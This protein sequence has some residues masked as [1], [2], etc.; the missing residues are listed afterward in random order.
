MSDEY[1]WWRDGVIY[2]IY[3]RSYSDSN[4]DGFGDLPGI[5]SRLDYL[6]SLGVD[7]IWL[8]PVYPSPDADFGYDISNHVDIDPRFGD[9]SDFEELLARAH[10][11]NIRVIL[12]LV[13][14]HTSD[15]HAW[16]RESAASRTNPK[17]DWYIWREQRNDWQSAFGGKA[18]TYVPE[19]DQYYYHMFLEE[20]PDVNWRNPEVRQAQLEVVRFW[21]ERGVDGFRLDVFNAYFKD[22][23]FRNNPPAWGIRAFDRQRHIYD[24]D[25]P[26]MLPLLKEMRGILD[27]YDERYAVGETF[28]SDP[29]YAALYSG[30][31]MLQ[32][33]FNFD[34]THRPFS[35]RQFLDAILNWEQAS[36]EQV[37][38]N[39][40]LSNHDVKRSATRYARGEDDARA[41]V[42]L[43]LLLTMRGTPFLYYGEE[44]GMRDISLRRDQ[45]LDPPGKKYWPLYK[46]RDGC[47]SPMQW[48]RSENAGFSS[49]EPWLPVHPNYP[50][51]NAAAQEMDPHSLLNLT[52][53]LIKLRREQAALRRGTFNYR[54]G[55]GS[56]ALVYERRDEAQ[57][58]LVALNFSGTPVRVSV[59]T[60]EQVEWQL[61][62]STHR[63]TAPQVRPDLDLAPYEVCLLLE[64]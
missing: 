21:L 26:E 44:I 17:A 40:V 63:E 24:C 23:Q 14:N 5:I 35:A 57:A 59:N 34:F 4:G 37:W 27:Q 31:D 36:G 47:R 49:G 13:L 46:G 53:R 54:A 32:A 56:K 50:L 48:D 1:L 11:R 28:G 33:A 41:R 61:L 58:V 3:P 62:L 19:R 15:Q 60:D 20:Q 52:R 6:E 22:D 16:F 2:Q 25:R 8:S 45:I 39:Y 18:W 38:P 12:D 55:K 9:L 64:A 43:A 51:R 42:M 10:Q 30:P 7:A 29:N